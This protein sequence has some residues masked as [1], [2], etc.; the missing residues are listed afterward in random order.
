[1]R[2]NKPKKKINLDMTKY[3]VHVFP[4]H[5]TIMKPHIVKLKVIKR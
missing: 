5:A 1:M 4:E 2:F 3:F